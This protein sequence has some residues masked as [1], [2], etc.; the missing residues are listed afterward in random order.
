MENANYAQILSERILS[1]RKEKGLTQEALAQQL[2]VSFQAV[3]KWENEQ[4][5]PDIALLPL[6]ADIFGVT[7]DSLFGR[8]PKTEPPAEEEPA[9]ET[10]A[11]REREWGDNPVFSAVYDVPWPDDQ[12]LR[13]V[14]YWGRKLLSEE[15]LLK[16][17]FTFNVNRSE[18]T[19]LLRYS[20]L[21]VIA[22]CALEVEGDI[23]GNATAGSHL[24]CADIGNN[25]TAGS[26]LTCAD[27]GN[28]ATAGSH[29]TCADVD[30]IR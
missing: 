14:V 9:A 4:S 27:V 20:P 12:T 8:E 11:R 13:G 26:H 23:Q 30:G 22:E 18:Y 19:W 6:L 28:N 1:L 3:S 24:T 21:N 10:T 7:V 29:L 17:L 15:K 5:C 2:G 16:K 25:A